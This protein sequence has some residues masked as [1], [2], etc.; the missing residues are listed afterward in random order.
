MFVDF[1][2]RRSATVS[3]V[4]RYD[5]GIYLQL[6]N[7]P[8]EDEPK[9][10]CEFCKDNDKMT[11]HPTRPVDGKVRVPDDLL[12]DAKSEIHVYVVV[13]NSYVNTIR[14][15]TIPVINRPCPIELEESV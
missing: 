12:R 5:K 1:L 13:I 3:P 14:E 10:L 4:Y 9:V 11:S 15:V 2:N 7:I 6:V 8:P